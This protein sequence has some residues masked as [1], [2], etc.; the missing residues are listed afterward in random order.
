MT[1]TEFH[2]PADQFGVPAAEA[3]LLAMFPTAQRIGKVPG[4][5]GQWKIPNG[6]AFVTCRRVIVR[7]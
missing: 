5:P 7:K 2:L 3:M 4:M 1:A 6:F